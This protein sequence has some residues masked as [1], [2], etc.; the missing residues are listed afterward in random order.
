M[1]RDWINHPWSHEGAEP[2][3]SSYSSTNMFY[4]KFPWCCYNCKISSIACFVWSL[5]K[6]IFVHSTVCS[7]F[8]VVHTVKIATD[9]EIPKSSQIAWIDNAGNDF[10]KS[11]FSKGIIVSLPNIFQ[12]GILWWSVPLVVPNRKDCNP[13]FPCINQRAILKNVNLEKMN[14]M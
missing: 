7:K 2:S 5:W 14:M 1:D 6:L 8:P 10:S 11:I 13:C 4:V 9:K 12:T 3:Y